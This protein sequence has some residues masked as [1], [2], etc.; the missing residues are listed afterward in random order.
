MGIASWFEMMKSLLHY[1]N[2]LTLTVSKTKNIDKKWLTNIA[3]LTTVT[4]TEMQ[5]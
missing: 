2:T 1:T 3:T 5:S 4:K